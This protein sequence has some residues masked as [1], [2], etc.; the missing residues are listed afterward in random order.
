MTKPSPNCLRC[1]PERVVNRQFG[2]RGPRKMGP[3]IIILQGTRRLTTMAKLA[4]LRNC[5]FSTKSRM[6]LFKGKRERLSPVFVIIT[7][8]FISVLNYNRKDG[9][10]RTEKAANLRNV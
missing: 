3:L 10:T 6:N 5:L 8:I 1:V 4:F 7:S 2:I 9:L